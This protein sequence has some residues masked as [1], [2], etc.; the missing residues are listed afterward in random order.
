MESST[1]AVSAPKPRRKWLSLPVTVRRDAEGAR[2]EIDWLLLA[3]QTFGAAAVLWLLLATAGFVW[4]RTAKE[5]PQ[6]RFWDVA[7]PFRWSELRT[8]WGNHFIALARE[9]MKA[10][11]WNEAFQ[12][13]RYGVARAPAN[14]EGRIVLAEI[15]RISNK[16]DLAEQLLIAGVDHSADNLEFLK[17]LFSVLL[18]S[19]SDEEVLGISQR[20]LAQTKATGVREQTI[21]LAGASARFYRG[22]YDAAEDLIEAYDLR[23]TKDGKLLQ[24]WIEWERGYREIALTRLTNCIRDF[25]KED[26]FYREMVRYQRVLGRDKTAE[27]YAVMRQLANPQNP[28]AYVD[29]LHAYARSGDR[30]RLNREVDAYLAEFSANQQALIT[31]ADFAA[32]TGNPALA[33]RVHELCKTRRVAVDVTAL[34]WIESHVVAGEFA[35]AI[36]LVEDVGREHP[37]WFK[38][39]SAVFN[40]LRAIA[41]F[42]LGQRD[43]GDLYL[44][45]FLGQ[46][47]LRA[48]NLVAVA[49]RLIELKETDAAR[50]VLESATTAD[51]RNQSALTKL[52]EIDLAAGRAESVTGNLQRLLGM[53]KPSRELLTRAYEELGSDRYFFAEGRAEVIQT[54]Q[55]ALAPAAPKPPKSG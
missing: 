44:K 33:R 37:D 22:D 42:G 49:N 2:F 1:N 34:M 35:D 45:D 18:Q 27:Q 15:F 39:R 47:N 55:D 40:G 9:E 46:R 53:R 23:S 54:L 6:A 28:A 16:P 7:L 17:V 20:L 10:Q 5:F 24:A 21:A 51:P 8:A 50:R 32:N 14:A 31:L 13:L 43:L 4:I 12:H 38:T 11:K 25:P 41:H 48:D 26:E 52:V 3:T 29:L 30:G 36:R 19:Q